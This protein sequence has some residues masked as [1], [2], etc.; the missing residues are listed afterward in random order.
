M[1]ALESL[2]EEHR[3]MERAASLLEEA[4]LKL[5]RGEAVNRRAFA[6]LLM[7]F[8]EFTDKCHHGKEE[9]ALFPFLESKGI[10]REGGPIGVMLMEHD[11]GR[12]LIKALEEDLENIER[13]PEARRDAVDSALSYVRLIREHIFKEDSIL[14][15]IADELMSADEDKRLVEEFEKIEI[16]TIGPGV[17]EQLIKLLDEIESILGR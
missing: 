3:V 5:Y 8:K 13:D 11:I 12:R 16:N 14:F 2:M 7:F 1:K 4:T 6:L 15:K 17:H 9:G 10:P